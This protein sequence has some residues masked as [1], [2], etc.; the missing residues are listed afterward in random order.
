MN[1]AMICQLAKNTQLVQ[2]ERKLGVEGYS[3]L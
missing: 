3:K 1:R 2:H